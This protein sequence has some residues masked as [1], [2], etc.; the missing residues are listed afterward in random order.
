MQKTEFTFQYADLRSRCVIWTTSS[1]TEIHNVLFL[2]TVQVN[3]LPYWVAVACPPRT[4]VIQGAPHWHAAPDGTTIPDFMFEFTRQAFDCIAKN[5]QLKSLHILADSQAAPGVLALF[6]GKKYAQYL[7]RLTLIQ[8]LG[9]NHQ[10]YAA[11]SDLPI[12][13]FNK[14]VRKNAL[15]QLLPLLS[16]HRLR[17]NHYLIA[18]KAAANQGR[19]NAQYAAGLTHDALPDLQKLYAVNPRITIICGVKDALFPAHEINNSLRKIDLPIDVLQIGS[20][21]HS[22]LATRQGK[23]LLAVAFA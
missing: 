11:G 15:H 1:A 22:P 19:A 10:S 3:K 18:T 5:I 6:R 2:G 7:E 12:S 21:P 4:A 9:L 20:V 23:R 17:Y 16:E 8:P 13:I 14:R